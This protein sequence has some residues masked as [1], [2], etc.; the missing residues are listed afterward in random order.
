M[1]CRPF[2][3]VSVPNEIRSGP[4]RNSV[5]DQ[6]LCPFRSIPVRFGKSL[7]QGRKSTWPDRDSN[8]GPLAY[9]ASTLITEL[10]SNAVDLWHRDAH[11]DYLPYL[12]ILRSEESLKS[13]MLSLAQTSKYVKNTSVLSIDKS[14]EDS[15]DRKD[16][17]NLI[18]IVVINSYS[19]FLLDNFYAKSIV[20]S[21]YIHFN[22]HRASE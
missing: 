13:E 3:S 1:S 2:W 21:M 17:S 16:S 15:L 9:H 12:A 4:F 7:S 11:T 6:F 22:Q 8:P 14:E 19:C 10:P 18:V 5:Q 20:N